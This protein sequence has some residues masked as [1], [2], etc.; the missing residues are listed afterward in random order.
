MAARDLTEVVAAILTH[1]GALV[2][3]PEPGRLAVV[4]PPELAAKLALPE[5]SELEF[6]PREAGTVGGA[7][8][9]KAP[10]GPPGTGDRRPPSREAGYDSELFRNLPGLFA[11]EIGVTPT[12]PH[13]AT[14]NPDKL[15]KQIPDKIVLANATF[16][17][18][19]MEEGEFSYLLVYFRYGAIADDKT[20][21]LLP[22]LI[23]TLN[24]S[25]SALTGEE[26][27]LTRGLTPAPGT[28]APPESARWLARARTAGKTMVTE[29]LADFIRSTEKRLNRDTRRIHEYYGALEQE[30]KARMEK[31]GLAH[32]GPAGAGSAPAGPGGESAPAE[33]MAEAAK[34]AVRQKAIALERSFKLQDLIEKYTLHL[35]L[36]PVAIIGLP[37]TAPIFRLTLKRRLATRSF[38]VT[39]NPLLKKLDPLPCE[40][41]WRPRHRA[42]LC[43]EQLH[44]LCDDCFAACPTCGKP[45]CRA[46]RPAGC[47]RCRR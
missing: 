33:P 6:A 32:P 5:F 36:E 37:T 45:W 1:Y 16:R 14:W 3:R 12:A 9:G 13:P 21:G 4:A 41:C 15:A 34:L 25:V 28:P 18:I 11:A 31:K 29:R 35:T 47:P 44:V 38:S 10:T 20:E 46:C 40:G 23:N 39:Y 27:W 43:D 7:R 8:E 22:L 2:E 19:G 26:E 24:G 17:T 30:L 42:W